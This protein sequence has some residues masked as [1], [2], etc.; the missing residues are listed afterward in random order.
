MKPLAV[1]TIVAGV[2][3]ASCSGGHGAASMLP[4]ARPLSAGAASAAVTKLGTRS[5]RDK[6]IAAPAGWSA[7]ATDTI[8]PANASDQGPLAAGTRL[9]VTLSLQMRNVEG[10][11]AAIAAR[12]RVSRTAFVAQYAPTGAQVSAAVGYLQSQGFSNVQ[13]APNNMLVTGT[14]PAATVQKAFNTTLHG[15][16]VGGHSYFANTAPAFVPSALGGNVVAVLGLT[17]VPG[18]KGGPPKTTPQDAIFPRQS[19]PTP[20]TQSVN[21]TTGTPVCP[22][23]YDPQTYNITYHA[24]TLGSA[25]NTE[26]AIFAVGDPSIAINDFHDNEA[27]FQLAQDPVNIV[28]VGT[29]TSDTSG[30]GEWTLDMTYTQA[31]AWDVKQIDLYVAPSF[32]YSDLTRAINRWASDDVAP[33]MNAS[34]G[35]CEAFPYQSGDMLAADMILVEAAVQGQTLFASTGDTGAYCGVSGVPPNGG[36]GGAPLVEYPASSPYAVAVG[37]T[38]LFSNVDGSYLGEQ[39]W[40]SGGGGLSQFEYSPSWESGVQPVSSTPVGLTF[41]GVPDVAMD[42]GLETGALLWESGTE[43]ITGGTSLASPLAAGT[44]ARMQN[45]HGGTLGFAAPLYYHIFSSSSPTQIAGPPETELIGPFHDVLQGTNG[46]YTA[47][48]KYDYT[49][50]LGSIDVARLAAALNQ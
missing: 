14:A 45:L 2:A 13:A 27:R 50:G 4:G 23:F 35:G 44:Y 21:T 33:V 18:L 49:T 11:K 47:L 28:Q 41:R 43:Y 1:L 32:A 36:V 24:T 15:F 42:A 8:V 26:V 39:A 22:R 40:Q 19:Q 25:G 38:D 16:S 12:Q 17:N 9:D 6:S 29:P 34:V 20:C 7:T 37:G 31:M 5:S 30:N 48:P 46:L 10:A 3:T